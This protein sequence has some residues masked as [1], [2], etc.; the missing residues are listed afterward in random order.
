MPTQYLMR[1]KKAQLENNTRGA[2]INPLVYYLSY[3]KKCEK[4]FNEKYFLKRGCEK[5]EKNYD[6]KFFSN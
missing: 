6:K 5:Q 4:I 1:S 3:L 2:R